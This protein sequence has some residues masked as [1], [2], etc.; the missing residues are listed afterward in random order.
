ML[1]EYDM[2]K[3]PRSR[4]AQCEAYSTT[5]W[6]EIKRMNIECDRDLRNL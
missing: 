3:F 6:V 4:G 5:P 1:I 2:P